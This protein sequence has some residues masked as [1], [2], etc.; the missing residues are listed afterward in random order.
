MET[1]DPVL[2]PFL[3]ERDPE[4]RRQLLETLL[5]ALRPTLEQTLRR[6]LKGA[7]AA[8]LEDLVAAGLASLTE[9][10][11]GL[12]VE[13]ASGPSI[14]NLQGYASAVAYNLYRG[15]LRERYPQR[16][17][18]VARVRYC[19]RADA[20]LALWVTPDGR[21][22]AGLAAWRHRPAADGAFRLER[23]ELPVDP[24]RIALADLIRR[25]CLRRGGPWPLPE[26]LET[27][28]RLLGIRDLPPLA[29]TE[30]PKEDEDG[31]G[32]AVRDS[33][34]PAPS[35]ERRLLDRERLLRLWQEVAL[36]PIRQRQALLLNLRDAR[37]GDLLGLFPLAG[38]ATW[39][40][41][42]G[43]LSC[44]LETLR[45]LVPRLPLEDREIA[46]WIGGGVTQRQVINLRKTAR[47]RLERRL[48]S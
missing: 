5:L 24:G 16:A 37:G 13:G 34:E 26:L 42:A 25:L 8:D 48:R 2:A 41:I 11:L 20:R 7:P 15:Y 46:D 38:I 43:L 35:P 45:A 36:L 3:S 9:R 40:E 18:L 29:W 1:P 23:L 31:A 47:A 14:S 17:R 6:L 28:A 33:P 22:C 12:E 21:A 39:S 32:S 44:P 30:V 27:L 4:K 19:L 10:L